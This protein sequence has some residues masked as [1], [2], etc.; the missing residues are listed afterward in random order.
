MDHSAWDG[1]WCGVCGGACAVSPLS[2]RHD[3]GGMVGRNHCPLEPGR[4]SS[5]QRQGAFNHGTTLCGSLSTTTS[6]PLR[7]S[8]WICSFHHPGLQSSLSRSADLTRCEAACEWRGRGSSCRTCEITQPF[9]QI[10]S[11]APIEAMGRLKIWQ[12][13]K[14]SIPGNARGRDATPPTQSP[15]RSSGTSPSSL[16]EPHVDGGRP[17]QRLR[18]QR[19]TP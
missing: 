12:K 8:H 13:L 3:V 5:V 19:R 11:A 15:A 6:R 16:Q 1:A 18:A 7:R 4:L 9:Q 17:C 10:G 2:A 14:T